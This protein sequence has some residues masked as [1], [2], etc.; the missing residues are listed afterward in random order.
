M[1]WKEEKVPP[2]RDVLR[3]VRVSQTKL[4]EHTE[5]SFAMVQSV[6]VGRRLASDRFRR[7]VVQA[8]AE[9]GYPRTE[10]ELFG[11]VR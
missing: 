9:L 2:L 8:L 5:Y 7:Q 4:S 11:D 3:A 1:T 10:R 6:C